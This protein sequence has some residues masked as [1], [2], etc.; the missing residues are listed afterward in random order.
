MNIVLQPDGHIVIAVPNTSEDTI[1]RHS[2]NTT[3]NA[4]YDDEEME[5]RNDEIHFHERMIHRTKLRLLVMIF[6]HTMCS[7]NLNC[8]VV[9]LYVIITLSIF[10]MIGVM[11]KNV[12]LLC[13]YIKML[14]IEIIIICMTIPFQGIII[15]IIF[16]YILK[17]KHIYALYIHNQFLTD[18][19]LLLNL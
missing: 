13:T 6:L 11:I 2:S 9:I 5:D 3:L 1:E 8:S 16:L 12:W 7:L 4:F 10:G 19:N 18:A 14:F 17:M 15:I